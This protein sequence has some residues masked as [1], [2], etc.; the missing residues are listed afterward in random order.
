LVVSL[1]F[2]ETTTATTGLLIQ[3]EQIKLLH[4]VKSN[5]YIK[6]IYKKA[7]TISALVIRKT[8]SVYQA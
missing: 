4:T 3:E 7:W 8:V 5:T 6:A 2:P 1:Q